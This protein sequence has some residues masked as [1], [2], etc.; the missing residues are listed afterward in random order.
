MYS[1]LDGRGRWPLSSVFILFLVVHLLTSVPVASDKFAVSRVSASA[2]F[3]GPGTSVGLLVLPDAPAGSMDVWPW[4]AFFL[5]RIPCGSP[6][7][8]FAGPGHI[9][10]HPLLPEGSMK[11]SN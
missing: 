10:H 7:V 8:D 2:A 9:R 3:P 1:D 5:L 4:A 11:L 6:L